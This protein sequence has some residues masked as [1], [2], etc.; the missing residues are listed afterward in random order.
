LDEFG[1]ADSIP[2]K[3]RDGHPRRASARSIVELMEFANE[4]AMLPDMSLFSAGLRF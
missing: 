1:G 4:F 3:H 2:D